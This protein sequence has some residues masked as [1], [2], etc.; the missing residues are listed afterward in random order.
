[1]KL[2]LALFPLALSVAHA[3]S[4]HST[5]VFVTDEGRRPVSRAIVT[6]DS[7]SR[8]SD[9]GGKIVLHSSAGEWHRFVIKRIGF[10]P[11]DT[12]IR[13]A[14]DSLRFVLKRIPMA[15]APVRVKNA[16]CRGQSPM[17]SEALQLLVERVSENAERYRLIATEYPFAIQMERQFGARKSDWKMEAKVAVVDTVEYASR[18]KSEYS[19][20]DV[21]LTDVLPL[22]GLEGTV[23][24][25]DLTDLADSLFMKSHC[26]RFIGREVL[27]TEPVFRL[28]FVPARGLMGPDVAGSVYLRESDY[29]LIRNEFHLEEIPKR[30]ATDLI[31]VSVTT[32][33]QEIAPGLA[34]VSRVD[35]RIRWTPGPGLQPG[36]ARALRSGEIQQLQS[37]RWLRDRP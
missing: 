4:Q 13:I 21:I 27:R 32:D 23:A 28:E 31:S 17:T 35:S 15:L 30:L 36:L 8:F 33:F 34:V 18:T 25:P 29:Q 5:F 2:A 19:P 37:I 6:A 9:E 10:L 20:G 11:L 24:I 26:F 12:T 7:I 14:S 3:Q 22:N 16:E 1:M